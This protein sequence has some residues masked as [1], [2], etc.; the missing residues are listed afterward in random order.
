MGVVSREDYLYVHVHIQIRY[1][2]KKMYRKI[3]LHVQI[4]LT[5]FRQKFHILTV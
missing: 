1:T 5:A 4:H 3:G 2:M